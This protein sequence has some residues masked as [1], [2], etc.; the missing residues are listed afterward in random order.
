MAEAG[1]N[2]VTV[3]VFSWARLQPAPGELTAGWLDRVLD[4]LAGAGI[5]VDLATATASPPAWLVAAHPEILPVTADGTRLGFGSRQHYCP[6]APAYRAAAADLARRMA[7]R[8]GDHPAV[9]MWHIGNEYGVPRPGLLLRALGRGLPALAPGAVRG[10]GPAE[11]CLGRGG[12][13]PGLHELGSD[14][15]AAH[16]AHL[17]QPGPSAR[18]RPVQLRR[19][20][21]LLYRGAGG[22]RRA[23]PRQA[24]DDQLHWAVPPGGPVPLV[25]GGTRGSTWCRWT[26]T[27]IRPTPRRTWPR[28]WPA[29]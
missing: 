23:Q 3:G 21:R 9:A 2:L 10:A 6:S 11:R 7:G 13:E 22:A 29:T 16:R 8:Y 20:A 27:R 18:L 4:L 14:R 12:L 24:G 17:R 5:W 28:P 26:T 19:A 15:A 25:G 1:V